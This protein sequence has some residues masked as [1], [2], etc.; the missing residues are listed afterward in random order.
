MV[1]Y[2]S[3]LVMNFVI[4]YVHSQESRLRWLIVGHFYNKSQNMEK[5]HPKSTTCINIYKIYL[6]ILVMRFLILRLVVEVSGY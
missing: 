3:F 6:F 2:W 4:E 5:A 1:N